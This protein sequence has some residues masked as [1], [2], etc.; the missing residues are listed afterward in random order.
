MHIETRLIPIDD[1]SVV[2]LEGIK[3]PGL[4][5]WDQRDTRRVRARLHDIATGDSFELTDTVFVPRPASTNEADQ[6]RKMAESQRKLAQS[7][8]YGK[9]QQAQYARNHEK[10]LRLATLARTD[11]YW[12]PSHVAACGRGRILVGTCTGDAKSQD[13]VGVLRLIDVRTGELVFEESS[14][15][16][17]MA[18]EARNLVEFAAIRPDGSSGLFVK[19]KRKGLLGLGGMTTSRVERELTNGVPIA[20]NVEAIPISGFQKFAAT[21]DAWLVAMSDERETKL[22]VV[23]MDTGSRRNLHIL[24]ADVCSLAVSHQSSIVAAGSIGGKVAILDLNTGASHVFRPVPGTRRDDFV[25]VSIS[26]AGDC[27][28]SRVGKRIMVTR[29]ADG[30]SCELPELEDTTITDDSSAEN[31]VISASI[32]FVGQSLL[33]VDSSGIQE[34]R[35]GDLDLAQPDESG[36][37]ASI[38]DLDDLDINAAP[39]ELL[40]QAGLDEQAPEILPYH[41]PALLLPSRPLG[42]SG[43]EPPESGGPALGTTRLGGWPDLASDE[44]WPMWRGRPMA[45]LAQIDLERAHAQIPNL[46]VPKK[47]VL[48]FF[49]GC[50]EDTYDK[51]GDPRER[52]MVDLLLGSEAEHE[53]GW[54][55]IYTPCNE[56]LV[57]KIYDQAPL[58]E[59]FDPAECAPKPGGKT[60]PDEQTAIFSQWAWSDEVVD[61]Y[62]ALLEKVNPPEDDEEAYTN[63]LL[64]Q[65]AL[66]QFTPPELFCASASSGLDPWSSIEEPQAREGSRDW[67]LLLQLVSDHH[68]DFCWG[69]AGHI[70]FYADRERIKVGDFSKTWLFFEN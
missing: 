35:L 43:W 15:P 12:L 27:V 65:P 36:A 60:F 25:A 7:D 47:G 24:P 53:D 21:D 32:C 66:I 3:H 17:E 69:D 13:F 14:R 54:K 68:A 23:D 16:H 55:V 40:E 4:S 8:E 62:S 38:P 70:Y 22:D 20:R 26:D 48:S 29:L 51:D 50:G 37:D 19:T 9:S 6:H 33:S 64:G 49:L 52:Y 5:D 41:S 31:T 30:A 2:I 57:R 28:V 56:S 10:F 44:R 67:C 39:R 61:R 1:H 45:F 34:Y 59:L 18:M 58:P 42:S 46:M 11:T 63:Q